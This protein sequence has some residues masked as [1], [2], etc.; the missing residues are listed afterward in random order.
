[1]LVKEMF[2]NKRYFLLLFLILFF[3]E[4]KADDKKKIISNFQNI[5]N[6][7]FNFEQ[8]IDGKIE[9]GKCIIEYPKKIYCKYNTSNN[10]TLVSN[11][12]SLVIR[13]DIGSY[14][15]YPLKNT[16]LNLILD[17]NF[18]INEI[19]DLNEKIIDEKLITF[20]IKKNE[21]KLDIFFD[22]DSSNIKGWKTL[23][24]YQNTSFTFLTNIMIN[25]EIKANTFKLP[26]LN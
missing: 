25:Q 4:T 8:N 24:V 14:Y 3:F 16:P 2:Y 11:G 23:D 5:K 21:L 9:N 7:T 20:T 19:I 15:R 17:K 26:K 6:L 18:I 10:K 13:T 12:N 22:K 1:M